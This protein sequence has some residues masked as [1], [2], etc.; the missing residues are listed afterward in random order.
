ML[1]WKHV[2]LAIGLCRW[3]LLHVI[4]ECTA[5]L[6]WK[7]SRLFIMKFNNKNMYSHRS[8]KICNFLNRS[9]KGGFAPTMIITV[10][11]CNV[12]TFLLS[13]ESPQN[14]FRY[15][16]K[17]WKE[18]KKLISGCQ[19]CWYVTGILLHNTPSWTLGPADRLDFP[20]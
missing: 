7:H 19:C 11:F 18:A 20:V 6:V 4:T 14:V 5:E 13:D 10:F 9:L 16:I 15:F 17:E 12:N 1:F 2:R 3:C 8:G